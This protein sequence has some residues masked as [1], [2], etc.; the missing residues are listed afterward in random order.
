MNI[1]SDK[2]MKLE[3][4]PYNTCL[5]SVVPN[6]VVVQMPL[7]RIKSCREAD[8][9]HS[10]LDQTRDLG[11]RPTLHYTIPT[12]GLSIVHM[13]SLGSLHGVE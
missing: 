5:A 12:T 11:S 4:V 8:N 13:Y 2:N 3:T 1:Q 7:L 10:T 9:D 6:G